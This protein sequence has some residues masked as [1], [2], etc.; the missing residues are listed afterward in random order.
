MYYE[1][2]FSISIVAKCN[3]QQVVDFRLQYDG[4]FL[5]F[6]EGKNYVVLEYPEKTKGN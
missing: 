5:N 3:S 6:K 4:T 2:L 1:K